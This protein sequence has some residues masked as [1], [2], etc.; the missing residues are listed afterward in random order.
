MA[1]NIIELLSR[2]VASSSIKKASPR[3]GGEYHSPC[4]VCGGNDRFII[5][6]EQ[7]GGELARKHNIPGTWSCPRHCGNGGDIIDFCVKFLNLKFVDACAELGIQLENRN[8]KNVRAYRPLNQPKKSATAWQATSF[9]APPNTWVQQATKLALEAHSRLLESE[10][11]LTYLAG[12]GLPLEAVKHYGLG[13]IEGEDK[14]GTCIYRQRSAFGLSI[15]TNKDGK[16]IRALRIPRGITIPYWFYSHTDDAERQVYRIRIRRRD[17]DKN[18]PKDA[19]FQLIP[20]ESNPFSAPMILHP[21]DTQSELT[22]W[23]IVEAELDAML[24]HH[25]LAGQVGVMSILT[26][27]GKPD[28]LGHKLLQQ[29]PRIL[30]ATDFEQNTNGDFHTAKHW[31]WWKDQYPQAKLWPV[32]KGKDPGEAYALGVDIKRW[33]Q[34]AMPE[35]QNLTQRQVVA[36]S[37]PAH[38]GA[39]EREKT[40]VEV[41]NSNAQTKMVNVTRQK[42]LFKKH[43]KIAN[44]RYG[45]SIKDWHEYILPPRFPYNVFELRDMLAGKDINAV[46]FSIPCPICGINDSDAWGWVLYTHCKSCPGHLHCIIDFVTSDQILE[47]L[48]VTYGKTCEN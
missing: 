4:P 13:Y 14:T 36:E 24:V 5:F 43:Y 41:E 9:F 47:P 8:S 29:S 15:K 2:V 48:E 18:N 23:V 17:I 44:W 28:E 35:C 37:N 30:V 26:V 12:R 6:P 20:Q 46:N 40:V 42:Q 19:K 16:P 7:Y 32:P 38:M 1:I 11:I 10:H 34:L 3:N 21:V 25:A 27:S 39:L 22:T 45:Q 31:Q 33:I